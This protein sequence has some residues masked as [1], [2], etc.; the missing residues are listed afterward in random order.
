MAD[1]LI[2][3]S[4]RN[5]NLSQV[6]VRLAFHYLSILIG[7]RF[8]ENT[9]SPY[10]LV[11]DDETIPDCSRLIISIKKGNPTKTL[12]K[13]K[14]LGKW[15]T[16]L[17]YDPIETMALKL[18]FKGKSGPY[19]HKAATPSGPGEM[20]LSSVVTDFYRT[21]C[22]AGLLETQ[23]KA[24]SLWP[25][26]SKFAM[27]VTHDIDIPRRTVAGSLRLLYRRD[28]PGG[29]GAFIDSLKAAT[30]LGSNPYDAIGQWSELEKELD[31]KST[32]FIFDGVRRHLSDPKYKPE[33]IAMDKLRQNSLEIALHTSIECF[34]G[35]GLAQAKL[36]L[37]RAAR[38]D[39]TGLRPHYLSALYPEY[40]QVASNVGFSY[41]SAL[42]FD[43]DIGFWNGIDLP[44]YP[45][46]QSNDKVIDLLEIPIAIMD[47][48]L[49]GEQ[50]AG[51]EKVLERAMGLL[52]QAS[53]T[54]GLIVLD[55]H[56]RT[57]YN[58]DYPGWRELF[59][60]I[61]RYGKGKGAQFFR[62]DEIAE[63]FNKSFRDQH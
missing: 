30:G 28:L 2:T 38:I 15:L 20:T 44:F 1:K 8:V 9:E 22:Q 54:G 51:S 59:T 57:F 43:Q 4:Y 49:I 16:A 12:I 39:L 29:F 48:G 14:V 42:G 47:C 13:D 31:V 34:S 63:L 58:R 61:V 7:V 56:Q 23:P 25:G 60:K 40:W 37:E 55:W 45:F 3:Y 11:V 5:K 46:D 50:S 19:S 27:A 32:Y 35:E 6:A 41:S 21:L 62:M 53:A 18:S 17:N 36:R 24:I 52:D 10:I 26:S 33:I